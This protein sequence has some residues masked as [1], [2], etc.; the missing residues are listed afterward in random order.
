MRPKAGKED[1]KGKDQR[2]DLVAARADPKEEKGRATRL[3]GPCALSSKRTVLAA[4]VL[5]VT[6]C[7]VFLLRHRSKA[8]RQRIGERRQVPLCRTLSLPFPS[9]SAVPL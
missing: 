2:R 6:W 7:T 4:R 5:T 8:V 1:P 9:R 3:Q